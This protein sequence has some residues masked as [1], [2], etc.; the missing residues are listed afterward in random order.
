MLRVE[1][2]YLRHWLIDRHGIEVIE[3]KYLLNILSNG[4]YAYCVLRSVLPVAV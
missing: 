3:L 1:R 2:F 4:C